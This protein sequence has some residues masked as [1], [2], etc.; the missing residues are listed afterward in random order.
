M[1][2]LQDRNA[3]VSDECIDARDVAN[4]GQ[5][6]GWIN[7]HAKLFHWRKCPQNL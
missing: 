3:P 5:V 6:I 2:I 7:H 4:A 1:N